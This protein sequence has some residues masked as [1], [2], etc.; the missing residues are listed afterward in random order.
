M[1]ENYAIPFIL[2]TLASYMLVMEDLGTL[3]HTIMTWH[4]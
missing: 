3:C 4:S 2:Q 1:T